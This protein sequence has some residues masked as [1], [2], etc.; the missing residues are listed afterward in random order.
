MEVISGIAVVEM[1]DVV[2][3][4]RDLAKVLI[5]REDIIAVDSKNC[6]LRKLNKLKEK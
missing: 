2:T 1:N 5:E 6:D 3:W 4:H